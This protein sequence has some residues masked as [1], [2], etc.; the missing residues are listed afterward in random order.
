MDKLHS[1]QGFSGRFHEW[2]DDLKAKYSNWREDHEGENLVDLT[3]TLARNAAGN[4]AQGGNDKEDYSHIYRSVA[5]LKII[6]SQFHALKVKANKINKYLLLDMVLMLIEFYSNPFRILNRC[7]EFKSFPFLV[8]YVDSGWSLTTWL[9]FIQTEVATRTGK[10]KP[11][12]LWNWV[13][14]RE[15]DRWM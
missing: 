8:F 9:N 12:R 13:G 14:L 10:I 7:N 6:A 3:K 15:R 2:R 11:Q 4:S 5:S 1:Y